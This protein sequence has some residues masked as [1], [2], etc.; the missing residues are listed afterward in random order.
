MSGISRFARL[1]IAAPETAVTTATAGDWL[2]R[3]DHAYR[4]GDSEQA[5]RLFAR[6]LADDRAT[7]FAW[8]GQLLALLD[9]GESGEAVV[10][11]DRALL[12]CPDAGDLWA[13]KAMAHARC[14][15]PDDA[16]RA[17][18]RAMRAADA[19]WLT[20]LGRGDVFAASDAKAASRS[21]ERAV[22]LGGR[23]WLPFSEIARSWRIA[24][25]AA[26]ACDAAERATRAAPREP[27]AWRELG[28]AALALCDHARA[29][30]AFAEA[31]A[32]SPHDGIA[33]DGF[34]ASQRRTLWQS[35]KW[36]FRRS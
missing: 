33:R 2:T 34:A 21:F 25:Q 4:R 7:V 23:D 32:L 13:A 30:A 22:S 5:L 18:D 1:E 9:L 19:G 36:M 17:A 15:E 31:L 35:L 10:W 16:Y 28:S 6:A 11:A 26:R 12:A 3:A 27:R 24:G 29:R 20:W 8:R 14:G